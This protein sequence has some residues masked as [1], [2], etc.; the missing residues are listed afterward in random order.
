MTNFFNWVFSAERPVWVTACATVASFASICAA[1]AITIVSFEYGYWIIPVLLWLVIPAG[2][3]V[4]EY[5]ASHGKD[6]Q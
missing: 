1:L 3:L 5:L 2:L 4:R 6:G